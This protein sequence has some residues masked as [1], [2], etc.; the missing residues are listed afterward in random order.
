MQGGELW[1]DEFDALLG[2]SHELYSVSLSDTLNGTI[3][4]QTGQTHAQVTPIMLDRLG[5]RPWRLEIRQVGDFAAGKP[6]VHVI[7]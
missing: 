3:E 2:S 6:L 1:L 4:L 5:P 7:D